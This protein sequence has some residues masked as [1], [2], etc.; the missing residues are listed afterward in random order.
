MVVCV[1]HRC[2]TSC[3]LSPPDIA[4]P[5]GHTTRRLSC[6]PQNAAVV[7]SPTECC[8]CG[9]THRMLPLWSHPQNAAVVESPTECCRCG[10]THRM[11]PLWSHP[12]NAAVVESP[13][14]CCRCGVTHRMLPLWSH[15]KSESAKPA[16]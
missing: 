5:H 1:C 8:R 4:N 15:P 14:E 2:V 7:E 16:Y 9:V 10:V 13:T 3:L 11:L 12:Q 6:Q